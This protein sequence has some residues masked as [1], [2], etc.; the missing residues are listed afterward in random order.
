[1]S[2]PSNAFYQYQVA[3]LLAIANGGIC[4][5]ADR[6][7][8]IPLADDIDRAY[9]W[10]RCSESPTHLNWFK[11]FYC[12]P[13]ALSAYARNTGGS[14]N[15]QTLTL[16]PQ[17]SENSMNNASAKITTS[18]KVNG[19]ETSSLSNAQVSEIIKEQ[20]ASIKA[21]TDL[22]VRT[23]S[24]D[25]RIATLQTELNDFIAHMDAIEAQK[26]A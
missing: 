16:N 6:N 4:Y 13:G 3:T 8:D 2:Q 17:S 7:D 9:G 1:M 11:Y 18:F 5:R 15:S 24:L 10:A 22:P 12:V 23:A 20:T 25:K 14:V 19:V 26:S 21:L